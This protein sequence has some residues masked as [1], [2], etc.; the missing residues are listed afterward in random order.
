MRPNLLYKFTGLYFWATFTGAAMPASK[1]DTT[2][3]GQRSAVSSV[4]PL[5]HTYP[6]GLVLPVLKAPNVW[7]GEGDLI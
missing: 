1:S 3:R 6:K 4:C 2:S 7:A 5:G